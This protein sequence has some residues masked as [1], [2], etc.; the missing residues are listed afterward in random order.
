MANK[1]SLTEA[2]AKIQSQEITAVELVAEHL[3]KAKTLGK[4][5][6]AF[7]CTIDEAIDRAKEVDQ[8]IKNGEKVGRLAG[9]PFSV[10]DVLMTKGIQTTA[11]S[12][13]LKGFVAPYTA[14]VIEKLENEGAIIIGKNN[15]DPFAFGGSGENS[16]YGP[17]K[18]PLDHSRVPGGSSSGSAAAVAAGIGFFSIGTDTGGSIRQPAA[19]CG[20]AGLKVSYG[21]NSRYG[22]IAM[23]SSFDTPG[24]LANCVEDLALIEEIIAGK[25]SKDATTYEIAVPKY[26]QTTKSE[27]SFSDLTIGVPE[28]YF[29]EGL[30]AEVKQKVEDLIKRIEAEGAKVKKV[31]IPLIKYGIAVYYVLVPSEISSNM[32]RFDS[33]RYGQ[34]I[35][36]DYEQNAK[37]SRGELLESEVKR[38]IMIGTYTLSAGYAQQYYNKALKVRTKLTSQVREVLKEV[39]VIVGPSAPNIAFQIGEKASDPLNMYLQDAYTV[40]ANLVGMPGINI[41]CGFDSQ[42]NMP[43]GFQ[44]MGDR[45]SEEKL[46]KIAYNI[47][48]LTR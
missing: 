2:I 11:S 13:L 4:E 47:E 28:E 41:N 24:I 21:R 6:N 16:G 25:D 35:S 43:I 26:S 7:I 17:T 22:L 18:N 27:F 42:Y 45:F 44:M 9:I 23:A 36:D 10:K 30:D 48:K 8:K 38:R 46:L 5:L 33:V 20:L 39:D 14:T 12:Q 3:E 1:L 40:T 32:A 29:G 31:S 37:Q 34:R 15:S 19:F